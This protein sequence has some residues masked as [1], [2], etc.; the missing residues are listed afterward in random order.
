MVRLYNNVGTAYAMARTKRFLT[1][2]QLAENETP[3]ARKF[4]D[5]RAEFERMDFDRQYEWRKGVVRRYPRLEQFL[6]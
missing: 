1:K 4:Q 5:A 2:T 3:I 6:I